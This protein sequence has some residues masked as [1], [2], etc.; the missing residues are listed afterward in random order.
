[1]ILTIFMGYASLIISYAK[2]LEKKFKPPSDSYHLIQIL[3]Q[4]K[5]RFSEILLFEIINGHES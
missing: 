2:K 4:I 1:M 3:T 5:V